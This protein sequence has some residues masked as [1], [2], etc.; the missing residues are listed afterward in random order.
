MIKQNKK[1][2]KNGAAKKFIFMN[3]YTPNKTGEGQKRKEND[4]MTNIIYEKQTINWE[5]KAY[6]QKE[7]AAPKTYKTL[8]KK[9][10]R[11]YGYYVK[12]PV[13]KY[14]IKQYHERC[15]D[16]DCDYAS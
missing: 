14:G 12:D 13:T 4:T 2:A 1:G 7:D 10:G 15:Q 16:Y 5:Q 3:I 6:Y 11:N 8:N 9:K